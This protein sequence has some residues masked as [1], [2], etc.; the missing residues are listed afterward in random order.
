MLVIK[1]WEALETGPVAGY[2]MI[3][4]IWKDEVSRSLTLCSPHDGHSFSNCLW[5]TA[6]W[7]S[8]GIVIEHT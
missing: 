5:L 1:F 6:Y 3:S 7:E 8:T 2:M 4:V